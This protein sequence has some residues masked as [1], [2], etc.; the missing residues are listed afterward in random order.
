[1]KVLQKNKVL[2]RN[3]LRY[4]MTERNLLSY[5]RHPFIVQLHFAFQTPQCLVLVLHYCSGGNL[6]SMLQKQGQLDEPTAKVC[7]SQIFLAIEHLHERSVVY[8]DLKPENVV[9]DDGFAMLT[10]F[11]LSKESVEGLQGTQSFCGSTAYLA[12]EILSRAGH[13]PAVDLYGLGV[14]LYEAR[15]GQPPFYSRD[16]DTIYRNIRAA[17]LVIP[18]TVSSQ[19]S[20]LIHALMHRTPSQR[21]GSG[22]TSNVRSH[23]YFADVDFDRMLLK[24][25]PTPSL[26]SKPAAGSAEIKP[27]TSP[28]R[29]GSRHRGVSEVSGWEFAS[30]RGGIPTSMAAPALPSSLAVTA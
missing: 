29:Q 20:S 10:D 16:R 6:S 11:G 19:A 26:R 28:F 24:Q 4:M 8:R 1:M 15:V 7:I 3:L 17:Q 25:D 18:P 21:L 23:A 22:S 27:P 2:G 30:A 13:G 9:L 12:P 5:I 14:L